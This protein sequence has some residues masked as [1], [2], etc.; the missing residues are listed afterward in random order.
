[1]PSCASRVVSVAAIIAYGAPEEMPRNSAASGA[2]SVYWRTA[3][4]RWVRQPV[5]SKLELPV[6]VDRQRRV[7][8]EAPSLVDRRAAHRGPE[9]R[10]HDLIVDSPTRVVGPCLAAV[11][12]PRVLMRLLIDGTK[13]VYEAAPREQ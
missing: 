10:A 1:M 7:V 6:V 5:A 9:Q 11:R 3:A 2:A 12:P 13:C 4:G 8:R